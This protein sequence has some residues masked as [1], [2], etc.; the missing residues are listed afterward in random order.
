MKKISFLLAIIMVMSLIGCGAKPAEE[1]SSSSSELASSEVESKASSE[2]ISS[3]APL[4]QAV[5][6]ETTAISSQ[7]TKEVE[8]SS[9]DYNKNRSFN[10]YIFIDEKYAYYKFRKDI[11]RISRN[12]NETKLFFS[13][14]NDISL[15][16]VSADYLYFTVANKLYRLNKDATCLTLLGESEVFNKAIQIF[17]E[18]NELYTIP[19]GAEPSTV[20][21]IKDNKIVTMPQEKLYPIHENWAYEQVLN[22]DRTEMKFYRISNK[23][24]E[25]TLIT[26]QSSW[27]EGSVVFTPFY[28]DKYVI[29]CDDKKSGLH[30]YAQEVAK[31]NIAANTSTFPE[32]YYYIYDPETNTSKRFI[33]P[34][35][36]QWINFFAYE[37]DWVY[38][39]DNDGAIHRTKGDGS[40]PAMVFPVMAA[41]PIYII[42]DYIYYYGE[43]SLNRLKIGEGNQPENLINLE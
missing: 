10:W 18:G 41:N 40:A 17:T 37:G 32:L 28:T 19:F 33:Q 42:D 1:V 35:L 23:T 11:Y 6:S 25:R 34:I 29:Y 9:F 26:T 14:E 21:T 3:I 4:S 38:Y 20:T 31:G 8:L 36:N 7:P 12:G 43:M 5:S 39:K 16:T 15:F 2:E 24:G 22:K 30:E 13:S 27:S